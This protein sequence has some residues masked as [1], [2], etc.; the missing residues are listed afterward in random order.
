MSVMAT[1][2]RRRRSTAKRAAVN[3]GR[4]DIESTARLIALDMVNIDVRDIQCMTLDEQNI[5][6]AHSP[7]QQIV[8][9]FQRLGRPLVGRNMHKRKLRI[10]GRI[11]KD[12]YFRRAGIGRPLV[13]R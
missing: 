2:T 12:G 10:A 3:S 4:I 11:A 13:R 9:Q 7:G 8:A 6:K 1:T 5:T